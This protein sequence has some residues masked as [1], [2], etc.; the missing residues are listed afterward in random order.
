MTKTDKQRKN[1]HLISTCIFLTI[2]LFVV[3]TCSCPLVCQVC[4]TIWDAVG[5][6]YRW[7]KKAEEFLKLVPTSVF[8]HLNEQPPG[9]DVH[10][11]SCHVLSSL[12]RQLLLLMGG[13]MGSTL[14]VRFFIWLCNSR[15]QNFVNAWPRPMFRCQQE[16]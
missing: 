14:T 1:P 12:N 8:W 5:L 3:Y 10:T 11:F 9:L 13:N 2:L 15:H 7:N 4:M 6:F 16:S